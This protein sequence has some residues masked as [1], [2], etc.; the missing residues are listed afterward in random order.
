[1]NRD[2]NPNSSASNR[3]GGG[4]VGTIEVEDYDENE[5]AGDY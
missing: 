1:M 4:A 3:Y 5:F 2:I